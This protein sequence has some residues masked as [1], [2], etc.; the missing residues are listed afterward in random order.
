MPLRGCLKLRTIPVTILRRIL[1]GGRTMNRNE[2][3]SHSRILIAINVTAEPDGSSQYAEYHLGRAAE[4]P[5]PA[6]VLVPKHVK[7]KFGIKN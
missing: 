2:P 3:L 1:T 4:L 5:A 7:E 6:G